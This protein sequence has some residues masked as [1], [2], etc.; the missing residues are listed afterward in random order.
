MPEV[1]LQPDLTARLDS[2]TEREKAASGRRRGRRR[3]VEIRPGSVK[4]ARLEA[5]LS[6]GQVARGDISRTAIYFVETGKAKPSRET[7]ELIAERTGRPVDFF[8]A[9]GFEGHAAIRIAEVERLL[10]TGDNAGAV[11]AG[12]AA[13]SHRPD[14][15]TEA[16]LKLLA[17]MAYLRLAQPV[18][19]R[20][21]AAEARAYFERSGDLEMVAECLG[22]EASGAYLMEDPSALAIAQGALATVR[23]LKPVPRLTEARLLGVLGHTHIVNREWH[24]AI[25]CYAQAIDAADVVQDLHK[26]SL[27]YSGLSLAHEELGQLDQAGRFAQKALAIHQTLSDRLSLARSENNLAL[28]LLH[29]GDVAGAQTH[30]DRSMKLFEEMEVETGRAHVLL[31]V[32]EIALAR[33]DAD[34]AERYGLEAMAMAQRLGEGAAVTEAHYWLAQVALARGDAEAVDAEFA[35]ALSDLHATGRERL[36][37]YRARYAEILER[38]GDLAAAN[39]QLRLALSALGAP[40]ADTSSARTAIA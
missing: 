38:R 21:F 26:L 5:G 35:A 6:L 4:Q 36:A 1:E 37:R 14:P 31:T 2:S 20:R 3:G 15:E 9:G 17:S 11:A 24:A 22:N 28:L 7:L 34:T 19:G 33:R 32:A 12:E 16:R 13:L 23:S 29:S 18:V 10:V 30:V 25:E 40:S 27:M 39:R 8:L